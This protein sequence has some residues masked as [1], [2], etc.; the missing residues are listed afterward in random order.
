M[1]ALASGGGTSSPERDE[2]SEVRKQGRQ[3]I[4]PENWRKEA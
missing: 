1:L 3:M 4:R 2:E